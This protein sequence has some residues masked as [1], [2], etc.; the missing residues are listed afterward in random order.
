MRKPYVFVGVVLMLGWFFCSGLKAQLPAEVDSLLRLY[1]ETWLTIKVS[2]R[3]DL[4]K[5]TEF[6]SVARKDGDAVLVNV[7]RGEIEE[8][9]RLGYRFV[10][11]PVHRPSDEELMLCSGS[12]ESGSWD[13]YPTWPA[14]DSIMFAFE[15][16]YPGLCR[17]HNFL[18]LSSG[19]KLLVVKLTSA[20]NPSG[21]KPRFLYSST[22][23]GNETAGYILTLRLIDH[24]LGGYGTD[25]E[26]TWL[27]DN[28]EIWI[29]PLAN[30]DGTYY[31]GDHTVSGSI[32]RNGNNV[33][34]NRNYPDPRVGANPDG[35]PYQPETIAFMNLADTVSF[36]SGANLHSGAE[37]V[38][39]PW[40]TWTKFH[41][42]NQWWIRVSRDYADTV[43]ANS[44]PGF[45]N[46]L[47]NGI[48]NGAAWYVITGGRQD[49]MN[50]FAHCRELTLEVSNSFILPAS[51]LN[52]MWNYHHRSMIRFLKEGWYG[53]RGQVTDSVTGLP[54]PAKIWI[55][56]HDADS[57]HVWADAAT[58]FYY[59]PAY[60]GAF[61][62]TWSHPGYH[63][64]T[65][66]V[67]IPL[68]DTVVFDVALVPIGFSIGKVSL[69]GSLNCWYQG[70]SGRIM[71]NEEVSSGSLLQVFG[72]DGRLMLSNEN[73]GT[74]VMADLPAGVYLVALSTPGKG[75]L[76]K[77]LII[78]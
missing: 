16:Q 32:R 44:T 73:P 53:L 24:L 8:M 7:N 27:L 63:P 65:F 41:P 26:A 25:P 58:G 71:L 38:N 6:T 69:P 9:V 29:C 36:T 46:D 66:Q 56:G 11:T 15:S 57:S 1:G 49:Y 20:L 54:L 2:D 72:A 43:Q 23:H 4:R 74:S 17:T 35:N 12:A 68:Q 77:K 67:N 39:Y 10:H 14:F 5:L 52:A 50:Y 19:R 76:R 59:R 51:Q 31:G 18:T 61:Q 22:M 45:F 55:T 21:G 40:D 42:D 37:V 33:D 60:H 78:Y 47:S 30:P 13:Y 34:L 28:M 64:K 62:V 48:T 70:S 75:L 3:E